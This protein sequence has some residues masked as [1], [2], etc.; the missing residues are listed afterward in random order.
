MR[1]LREYGSILIIV[2]G[3][4]LIYWLFIRRPRKVLTST[5]RPAAQQS[6]ELVTLLPKDGIPAIFNPTF[7]SAEAAD[8]EYAP[9][10]LVMGVVI[11]GDARAYSTSLLNGHEIVND[12]VGGQ[13]IAVTW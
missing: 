4:A 2:F 11:N 5:T 6:L 12:V 10:E 13:P 3:A 1:I 9:D 7:Y 8:R